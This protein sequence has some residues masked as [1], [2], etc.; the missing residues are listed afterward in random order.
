MRPLG[1]GYACV[2]HISPNG[3]D[4]VDDYRLLEEKAQVGQVGLWGSCTESPCD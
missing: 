1:V 4:R 2:L 3:D